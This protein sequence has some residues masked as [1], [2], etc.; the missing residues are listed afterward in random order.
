MRG[1]VTNIDKINYDS[2]KKNTMY[3]TILNTDVKSPYYKKNVN[4]KYTGLSEKVKKIKINSFLDLDIATALENQPILIVNRCKIV[5]MDESK[6]IKSNTPK[7]PLPFNKPYKNEEKIVIYSAE[8]TKTNSF[9]YDENTPI[10]RCAIKFKAYSTNNLITYKEETTPAYFICK[11]S[12]TM[13]DICKAGV[14]VNIT[15]R[16]LKNPKNVLL[17]LCEDNNINFVKTI[18][19][20][21]PL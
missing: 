3:F 16:L 15:G 19:N 1:I 8:I 18:R 10:I 20:K 12:K 14:V 9:Y 2:D 13:K 17:V 11:Y 4:C 21:E 7:K 5:A 6:Y